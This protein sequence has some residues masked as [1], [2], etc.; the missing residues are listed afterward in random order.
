MVLAAGTYH[1]QI[2]YVG[3]TLQNGQDVSKNPKV[4]FQA[5]H[6]HSD[7]GKCTIYNA[8]GWNTFTQDMQLL[9]CTQ[10]SRFSDGTKDT[11][12]TLVVGANSAVKHIH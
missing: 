6:F 10:M 12:Y 8:A 11:S 1:F 2:S 4:K 5:V 3:A 7:S 9:P